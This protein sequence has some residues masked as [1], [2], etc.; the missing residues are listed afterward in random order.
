MDVLQQEE[1]L[2]VQTSEV[3]RGQRVVTLD[4]PKRR[5]AMT[6]DMGMALRDTFD[7]LGEDPTLRVVVVTG[8]PPA[9][10]AGGDLGMLEELGRKTRDEGFDATQTM[11][12]FYDLFLSIM[13]LPVPVVGAIN[14]HAVGAGAC[15]A[16]A[17]DLRVIASS[18]KF[19]LNFARLGLHPGMGGTW[20][21][22]KAVGAQR[23]AELL[24]TG[25]LA[26]G[27]EMCRYGAALE[28]LPAE[29]VL[30][31]A[32]ELASEIARSSPVVCRQLKRSMQGERG[33]T[34]QLAVEAQCQ[35]VNYGT[36][37]LQEGLRAIRARR[38]PE[39]G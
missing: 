21:L 29:Q 28:A 34:D 33:L 36:E 19:G 39:F 15:I 10:S 1:S 37:D 8:T 25:R 23:A 7:A 35:A 32:L 5:N 18:C 38:M 22:P 16:L 14:G 9:F 26:S 2:S 11:L 17:T 30:P 31:R 3:G 24:Y 13:R 6:R 20:L 12:E 27:E 4:D